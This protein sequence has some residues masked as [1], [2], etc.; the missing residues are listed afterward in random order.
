MECF[1]LKYSMG[2]L[3]QLGLFILGNEKIREVGGN[4]ITVL[5]IWKTI[6]NCSVFSLKT[7]PGVTPILGVIYLPGVPHS[8]GNH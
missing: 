4:S 1:S 8:L 3:N 7:S 6:M 2:R 5:K